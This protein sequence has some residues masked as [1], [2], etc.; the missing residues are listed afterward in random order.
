VGAGDRGEVGEGLEGEEGIFSQ[1][2][3]KKNK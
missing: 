2:I 3:K 1:N